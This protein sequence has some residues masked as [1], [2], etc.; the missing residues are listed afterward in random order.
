MIEKEAPMS[1]DLRRAPTLNHPLFAVWIGLNIVDAI[2]T[3]LVLQGG[4]IEINPLASLTIR[5]FQLVPALASK[6]LLAIPIGILILRWKPRLL[7]S[8]NILI[9]CAIVVTIT[10]VILA[11]MF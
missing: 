11:K 5:Y 1:T 2:A 6:V 9:A 10:S 4:G 8:L 7:F 3:Y